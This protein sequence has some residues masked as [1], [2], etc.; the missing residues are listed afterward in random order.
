MRISYVAA[1]LMAGVFGIACGL[2]PTRDPAIIEPAVCTT[3]PTVTRLSCAKAGEA[4]QK[5]Y[6]LLA[7]I[8]TTI[9]DN[10]KSEVWTREQG[11]EYLVKSLDAREKLDRAYVVF[12]KGDYS[13]AMEQTNI[14]NFVIAALQKEIAA[15]ARKTS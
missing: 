6:I 2:L 9:L 7:A 8:N 15:Q 13:K 10:V 1:V 3:L 14:I 11:R 5:G 4:L 12:Q